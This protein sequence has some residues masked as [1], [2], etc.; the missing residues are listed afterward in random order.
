MKQIERGEITE[1]GV[2]DIMG[3]L[4]STRSLRVSDH[5]QGHLSKRPRRIPKIQK[6]TISPNK[7]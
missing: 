5:P 2:M 3:R 4:S 7:R 6:E 1:K